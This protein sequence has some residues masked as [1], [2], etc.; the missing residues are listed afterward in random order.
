MLSAKILSRDTVDAIEGHKAD[1]MRLGS[2]TET[3]RSIF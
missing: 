2:I 3:Q 1:V